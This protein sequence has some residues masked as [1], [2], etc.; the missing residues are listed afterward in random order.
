MVVVVEGGCE[1]HKNKEVNA[2]TLV[3]FERRKQTAM[4]GTSA[5][6]LEDLVERAT[7]HPDMDAHRELCAAM[8]EQP[9]AALVVQQ[10]LRCVLS[11]PDPARQ[12]LAVN[13]LHSLAVV[14][15]GFRLAVSSNAEWHRLLTS[16]VSAPQTSQELRKRVMDMLQDTA[17][18]AASDITY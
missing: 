1:Q 13:L 9:P 10:A 3:Y 2:R 7:R 8:G 11:V 6:H 5:E 16:I 12:V 4:D 18:R 15:P 17:A 14:C